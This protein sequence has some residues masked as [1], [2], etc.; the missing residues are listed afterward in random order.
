LLR[1]SFKVSANVTLAM[2][3]FEIFWEG[4][5]PP[6]CAPGLVCRSQESIRPSHLRINLK[7]FAGNDYLLL[8]FT[9]FL[10]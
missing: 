5:M 6:G 2:Q 8:A 7:S 10:I 1:Y 4:Q 9:S 3:C